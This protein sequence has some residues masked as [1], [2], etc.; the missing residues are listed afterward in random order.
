MYDILYIDDS[1][2]KYKDKVYNINIAFNRVLRAIDILEDESLEE[3][4]KATY[5]YECFFDEKYKLN[6]NEK[7]ELVNKVFEHINSFARGKKK[8]NDEIVMDIKQDFEY[9]YSSFM[10][11]YGIDLV[12]EVDKLSWIKFMSLLGG[13]SEKTKM[14][15][16]IKIRSMKVPKATKDNAE[17]RNNIIK[18][19]AYYSLEQKEGNFQQQ[20]NDLFGTLKGMAK[21]KKKKG[22]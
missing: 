14:S 5:S 4:E 10:M 7:V 8:V 11:N 20:L 13:L 3:S 19:K 1:K 16:V 17:H 21:P 2:I 9:I 15:E 22:R 12:E 6:I 18:M